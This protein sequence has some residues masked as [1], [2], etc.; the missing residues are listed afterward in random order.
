MLIRAIPASSNVAVSPS[1][2]RAAISVGMFA[3]DIDHFKQ[4]NDT[5]G[6]MYG[7]VVLQCLGKRLSDLARDIERRSEHAATTCRMSTEW[8]RI[9]NSR[10]WPD[11]SGR[12]ERTR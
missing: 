6:H 4:V 1:G 9:F 7:D 5:Y 3:I 2:D 8:R 10:N 11:R 12:I